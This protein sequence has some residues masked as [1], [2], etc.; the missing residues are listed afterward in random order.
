MQ[1]HLLPQIECSVKITA[2]RISPSLQHT[3]SSSSSLSSCNPTL[4]G[5]GFCASRLAPCDYHLPLSA[6][7]PSAHEVAQIPQELMRYTHLRRRQ[8]KPWG[9]DSRLQLSCSSDDSPQLELPEQHEHMSAR[10]WSF[11]VPTMKEMR[12]EDD[13][14]QK[15]TDWELFWTRLTVW[16]QYVERSRRKNARPSLEYEQWWELDTADNDARKQ[17]LKEVQEV[18]CQRPALL[19]ASRMALTSS[20]CDWRVPRVHLAAPT[21][22]SGTP[23]RCCVVQQHSWLV[24]IASKAAP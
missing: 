3:A 2:P 7:I 14:P 6:G 21:A 1:A 5:R 18:N 17:K 12:E 4:H 20:Y 10:P 24:S 16:Q 11:D 19:L 23:A 13:W 9:G 15:V 22:C 8:P